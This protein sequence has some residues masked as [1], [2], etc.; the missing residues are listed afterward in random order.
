MTDKNIDVN[1]VQIKVWKNE[2]RL[3]WTC[4][5]FKMEREYSVIMNIH[6][7]WGVRTLDLCGFFNYI[8]LIPAQL[9]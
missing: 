5:N 6:L 8:E 3:I 4:I 2:L 1:N 9:M 7:L